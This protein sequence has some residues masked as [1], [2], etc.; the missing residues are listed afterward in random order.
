MNEIGVIEGGILFV[1]FL[2]SLLLVLRHI[3]RAFSASSG[4]ADSCSG[5]SSATKESGCSLDES[6]VTDKKISV[7]VSLDSKPVKK[8]ERKGED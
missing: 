3:K 8:E 7:H 1:I 5:C 6:S 4:C 2:V